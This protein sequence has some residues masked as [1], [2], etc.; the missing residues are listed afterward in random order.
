MSDFK[1]F[2]L[3]KRTNPIDF[4]G[5]GSRVKVTRY[6]LL[7]NLVNTIQTLPFK[8]GPST[9][10]LCQENNTYGFSRSL[11]KG[12]GHT[13]HIV[14][15]N[16]EQPIFNADTTLLISTS[17]KQQIFNVVSMS[18]FNVEIFNVETTS[19]FN[20][21]T[22]SDFNVFNVRIQRWN[23]VRFQPCFNLYL[24]I[25]LQEALSVR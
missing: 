6:T 8:L 19:D 7:L 4:Q 16:V 21:E 15:C 17:G 1:V 13:I 25:K 14:V 11:V 9:Y 24:F 12:Q 20:V 3:D 18:D 2:N 23:N 10:F 5:Q 22:T